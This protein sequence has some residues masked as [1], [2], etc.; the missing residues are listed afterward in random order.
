MMS[1]LYYRLD[2]ESARRAGCFRVGTWPGIHRN[3]HETRI[4]RANLGVVEWHVSKDAGEN[5]WARVSWRLVTEGV[6]IWEHSG[7]REG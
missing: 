1:E 7:L 5:N 2:D 6:K 4:F 3:F